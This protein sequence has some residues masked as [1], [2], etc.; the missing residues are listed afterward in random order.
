MEIPDNDEVVSQWGRLIAI[1][2]CHALQA[3]VYAIALTLALL[4]LLH[5]RMLQA[6]RKKMIPYRS[7]DST[8][9][10]F[11]AAEHLFLSYRSA[12]LYPD[13]KVAKVMEQFSTPWPKQRYRNMVDISRQCNNKF[14][15]LWKALWVIAMF[16]SQVS[17]SSPH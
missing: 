17:S 12:E 5:S 15:A 6:A 8:M 13:L 3:R 7:H 4:L 9:F 10:A 16:F 14:S 1:I 2:G 11:N